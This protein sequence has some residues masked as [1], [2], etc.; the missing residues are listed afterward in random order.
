MKDYH[1]LVLTLTIPL[2]AVTAYAV[3]AWEIPGINK[4]DVS[5]YRPAVSPADSMALADVSLFGTGSGQGV[6]PAMAVDTAK[7]RI[8]F[9]GDS[10]L[11][12]LSKRFSD[13]SVKN[14]HYLKSIIWY[15]SSTTVWANS[16]TLQHFIRQVKPTFIVVCLGS[17]ELFV[18]D[19]PVRDKAIKKIISK[20]GSTPYVWIGPPNWKKDTGIDSLILSNVGPK[21]YFDS[22]ELTLARGKDHAHP[23][24]VAARGWM[25]TVAVWMSD[26]KKT[27][28]AIVMEY[29]EFTGS[30]NNAVLLQPLK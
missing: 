7:Q 10:M 3:T 14:G 1:K 27:A 26:P 9:F 30:R 4:A 5:R 6:P 11:E 12:G 19:L 18:R 29:P 23:T 13:Y 24:W 16:D 21:R 20:I 15:S 8:L 25:D 22:S 2:I 17:N 28:H